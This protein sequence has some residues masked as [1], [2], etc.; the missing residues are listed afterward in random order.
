[1]TPALQFLINTRRIKTE[2]EV[3]EQFNNRQHVPKET[4]KKPAKLEDMNIKV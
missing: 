3:E 1:M 2:Q 4:I